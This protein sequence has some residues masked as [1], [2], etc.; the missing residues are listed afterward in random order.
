MDVSAPANA[1]PGQPPGVVLAGER[2]VDLVEK[3]IE[4]EDCA[5]R[6]GF[7]IR[8]VET[9]VSQCVRPSCSLAF[10]FQQGINVTTELGGC[11]YPRRRRSWPASWS[12]TS[13]KARR[14][15][16]RE[17]EG[18]RRLRCSMRLLHPLC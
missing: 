12:G 9:V 14:Q 2:T 17:V 6:C 10:L 16:G 5:A 4:L 3:S 15:P 18:A 13:E 7:Y 1:V 11:L 8:S